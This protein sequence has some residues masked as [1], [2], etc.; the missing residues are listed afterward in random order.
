MRGLRPRVPLSTAVGVAPPGR[1]ATF[2]IVVTFE[3]MM[4]GRKMGSRRM[5]QK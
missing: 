2:E 3:V 1:G 5:P 4:A